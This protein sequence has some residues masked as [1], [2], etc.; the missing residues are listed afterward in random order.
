VAQHVVLSFPPSACQVLPVDKK[1]VEL[2]R[3]TEAAE[4]KV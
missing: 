2:E 3:L 4:E 1:A